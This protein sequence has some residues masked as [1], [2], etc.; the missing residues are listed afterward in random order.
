MG[1]IGITEKKEYRYAGI[2]THYIHSSSLPDLEAR[3]S[4]LIFKDYASLQERF[5][6]IDHTIEEFVTGLPEDEPLALVGET[7]EAIDRYIS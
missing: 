4:E 1:E 3:L 7:R 6:I 5:Q 2:A